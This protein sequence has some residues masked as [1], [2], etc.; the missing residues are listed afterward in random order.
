M[1]YLKV[2]ASSGGKTKNWPKNDPFLAIFIKEIGKKFVSSCLSPFFNFFCSNLICSFRPIN[3]KLPI[4]KTR[5]KLF[6]VVL[7]RCQFL[8]F[9]KSAK[10]WPLFLKIFDELSSAAVPKTQNIIQRNVIT[11]YTYM[12]S[13]DPKRI[14]LW[15]FHGLVE[16]PIIRL[17]L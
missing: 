13:W 15:C 9:Q 8:R 16:H 2:L 11:H 3:V 4:F 12:Y 17:G 10:F 6:F 14:N 5:K 1:S 7:S